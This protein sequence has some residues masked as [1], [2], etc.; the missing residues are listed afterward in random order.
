MFL[1]FINHKEIFIQYLIKV[2]GELQKIIG[3]Y[4]EVLQLHGFYLDKET[5]NVSFDIIIDFKAKDPKEIKSK[6]KEEIKE[7]YPQYN[8]SVVIDN[9]FSD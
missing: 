6:I 8:Y 7:Q 1:F 3:K 2:K 9:D 4:P 5:N